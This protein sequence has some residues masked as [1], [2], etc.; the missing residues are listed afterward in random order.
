MSILSKLVS[1]QPGAPPSVSF[2]SRGEQF[3]FSDGRS[4]F[5]GGCV[6][7]G[8]RNE[9]LTLIASSIQHLTEATSPGAPLTDT[10]QDII[11]NQ[12]KQDLDSAG[13]SYRV[14]VARQ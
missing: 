9:C 11:A 13:Y 4:R 5:V 10:Q 14:V 3:V 8:V 1:Q 6:W 7:G 2:T 12:V